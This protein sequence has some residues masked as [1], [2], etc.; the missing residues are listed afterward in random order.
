MVKAQS[1]TKN[2]GSL[3]DQATG[4]PQHAT[5]T[6]SGVSQCAGATAD[7]LALADISNA[8]SNHLPRCCLC[9][10]ADLQ[11]DLFLPCE[12]SVSVGII[13]KQCL[14]DWINTLYKGRCPRCAYMYRVLTDHTPWTKWRA[15]T[16]LKQRRARHIIGFAV[17]LICTIFIIIAV[18]FLLHQDSDDT[19]RMK[20]YKV[21]LAIVL[22]IAYLIYIFYQIRVYTR[23]YERLK[24]F[25]NRVRDVCDIQEGKKAD[26]QAR[27]NLSSLINMSE[28]QQDLESDDI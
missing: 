10:R 20:K 1:G 19:K 15:D 9:K 12:C 26:C 17:T 16:L 13:H 21:T 28:L 24:I 4:A 7:S 2:G 23:I 27:G 25:N 8:G 3:K 11:E 14:L 22:G 6:H 5:D 18:T